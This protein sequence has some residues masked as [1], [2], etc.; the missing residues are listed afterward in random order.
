MAD[1]GL[2]ETIAKGGDDNSPHLKYATEYYA[3]VG[4]WCESAYEEAAGDQK[5]VPEIREIQHSIDY[6]S[7]LQWKQDMPSYRAK[8]ITNEAL[9]NFWETI[10]L[11]TDIKPTFHVKQIG[12][13]GSYSQHEKVLNA[14]AR[15][16]AKTTQFNRR[17]AFWTMF[18]MLTTAPVKLYWN[19]FAKGDSGDYS[20][21]DIS[22]EV[23]RT[24][25]LLRLG[26]GATYQDDECLIFRR[27]R[28][29]DWIRRAYPKMGQLVKPEQNRSQWSAEMQSPPTVS[30]QLFQMLSPA[31]K[32]AMNGDANSTRP[33]VYPK[34]E[35]VE[36]W[37]KNDAI[38]ETRNNLLMGPQGAAWSYIV[39]PGQKL[40]PRGQLIVRSNGVVLYDEPN[41]YFHRKKP[42]VPLALYDV[43]WQEYAMSVV[44]PWTKQN[45][46]LNQILAGLLDN[47]KKALRPSLMA[48]KSAIHPDALR[49]IDSSK[50]GLKV[51]YNSNAATAPTWQQPP[52]IPGYVLNA[53]SVVD[54]SLKRGSGA[55][56]MDEAGGKKQVPGA[57]TMDRMTF[58]KTTSIRMMGGNVETAL[59][60]V[61]GMWTANALQFYDAGHRMELL[62][63][64][65]LTK[66]DMDDRP[67]TMI[68]DGTDSEAFVRKFKFECEKGSLLNIQRQDKIQ[69]GFALRK[70]R[71]L[72]RKGL[73]NLLDWNINQKENEAELMEE[74]KKQAEAMA[75]A[76]AQPGHA[77]GHK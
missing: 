65:G 59:D 7:G 45:D 20:D 75:A 14:L 64:S 36:Y 11:L 18:G 26:T 24:S 29:I 61:G 44:G 40:Y 38:N 47:V 5:D 12:F 54:K 25:E 52:N 37:R 9:W 4:S 66:E 68:P 1:F 62:G 50:P 19:P 46:I 74:A 48:P 23:L 72:S 13:E 22:M 10:G 16:W 57:D 70:N 28:T 55:A 33:S 53:Y 51:S 15:G 49:Q 58:S 69:V 2:E 73:F 42:F 63:D 43:P 6:L 77:K 21:G 39:K 35:V 56:A 31:M 76:G 17:M 8:P 60:E 67:G 71:D 3:K 34:A 30:P 41:A 32:R 27:V